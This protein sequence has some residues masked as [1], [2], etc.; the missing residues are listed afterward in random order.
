VR[1]DPQHDGINDTNNRHDKIASFKQKTINSWGSL[2][3][4]KL[5]ANH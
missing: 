4:P 5:P 3:N 2:S 1:H